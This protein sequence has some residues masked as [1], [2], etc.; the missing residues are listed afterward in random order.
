MDDRATA[1]LHALRRRAYGPGADIAA[2]PDA[3]HRLRD[4]EATERAER[5]GR[6]AAVPALSSEPAVIDA[7]DI[8]ASDAWQ[9]QP[10]AADVGDAAGATSEETHDPV[11][12][13]QSAARRQPGSTARALMWAG[14][15]VLVAAV[16]VSATMLI[17]AR[18]ARTATALPDDAGITHVTT[19]LPD[20][21][22]EIPE[23]YR[24]PDD[25][26]T[27]YDRFLGLTA[28][29]SWFGS[30]DRETQCLGIT[31]SGDVDSGE[32]NFGQFFAQGCSAGVFAASAE[33]LVDATM[34]PELLERYPAGSALQ[35]VLT[36]T[37]VDVFVAPPAEPS[38]TPDAS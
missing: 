22:T 28:F 8:P 23:P 18:T 9:P 20:A 2:D 3:A 30:E 14:S 26:A 16:A 15:L 6:D 32:E 35:F 33:L 4:L 34:P 24:G 31:A 38:P 27:V 21:D 29:A 13:E 19:L 36:P 17:T 1:E 11:G 25:H 5:A 37:G 12:H 7:G 10:D